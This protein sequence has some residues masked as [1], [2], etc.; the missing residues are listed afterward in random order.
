[1]LQEQFESMLAFGE[2]SMREFKRCGNQ[3][4]RDVFETICA[5]SNRSGGTIFLGVCDDGA[6]ES[7]DKE[8][9]PSIKRNIVNVVNN[10]N[11]FLP[12]ITLEFETIVIEQQTILRIWV[13]MS[14]SVHKFKGNVYDRHDDSDIIVHNEAL[15]SLLYLRK[16]NTFSELRIFPYLTDNELQLSKLSEYRKRAEIKHP[17]HPWK[18]MSDMEVLKSM[19]LYGR[20]YE[21]G[22]EGFNLAAALLLGCDDVIASI[23]PTYRTDAILRTEN[24]DRY[25]DR[26]I[27]KT[28]L[29]DAYDQLVAFCHKHL[30][31]R[32]CL[33]GDQSI[34]LRDVIVR[35]LISNSLIHREFSSPFPAKVLIERNGLKTENASR[36]FFQG[37]IDPNNFNPVPKNPVIANFF[38][39]IG[40]AEEMGSG[41]R[42]LLKCS[43]LYS[44]EDPSFEEGDTF[45]ATVPLTSEE[46]VASRDLHGE[47]RRAGVT[48]QAIIEYAIVSLATD[49]ESIT[50]SDVVESTHKTPRTVQRFLAKMVREGKLLA[51]G[52][53][54]SRKYYATES[55]FDEQAN[56]KTNSYS[57]KR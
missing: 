19:Q 46:E 17:D 36:A 2:T 28:N 1:M 5:F 4:G 34:S 41:T 15:L 26:I 29:I 6:I 48:E 53:T 25:D 18:R 40:L 8:A 52:N 45:K 38:N 56:A 35:E 22:I 3:P 9:V 51:E 7:L 20:N 47:G 24:L 12:A 16:Q 55:T 14:P 50:V 23:C 39:Q 49:R 21:T 33:M 30:P 10:P 57:P 32:F 43:R 54:R 27:V 11:V 42:N 44:G 37:T 13:P 31:D